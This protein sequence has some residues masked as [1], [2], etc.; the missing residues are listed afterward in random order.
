MTLSGVTINKTSGA[1][2]NGDSSNFY[3]VN[4]GL[5]A[6]DG[7]TVMLNNPIVKTTVDGGNGIFSYGKGTTVT[8]NNAKISTSGNSAGGI[9]VTGGGTMNVNNSTIETQGDHSAALRTD[10]GGGTLTV[11][12][13]SYTS[14]GAGSPAIYS[15]AAISVSN[16]VLNAT[17]SEALVIEGKNSI[18]LTDCDVTGNMTSTNSENTHNVMIYQ[19][20]SGDADTGT[21]AF[22]MTNGSLAGKKGDMIYI[23]NTSC[24]VDLTNV[25]L[26]MANDVLLR[27][28]GNSSNNWGKEGSN[29]GK[30]V[31]TANNQVLTDKII[32][33][34]ISSLQLLL[35]NKSSFTGTINNQKEGGSVIVDLDATSKWVLTG[36]SYIKEL[37]GSTA[38]IDTNGHTLYINGAVFK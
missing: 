26:T 16:A 11:N 7:A 13:G 12:G 1:A 37:K 20:M 38:N 9:M 5:L 34:K 10:R 35:T 2:G 21:S 3:G 33:D 24:T 8:V 4:A 31:F 19:S 30:C 29:G 15:T 32:V 17:N 27:I 6:M 14:N 28:A 23:T 18:T 22:A 36:D 25:K